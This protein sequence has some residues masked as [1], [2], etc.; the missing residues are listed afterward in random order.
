MRF[1]ERELERRLVDSIRLRDRDDAAL[2]PEQAQDREVLVRLRAR[3]LVGVDHEQEQVDAC[4]ARDHRAH[5][6]LVP[7]HVD[8]GEAPAVRQIERGVA[9]VDRDAPC[10]LL[11]EP[12]GVLSGQR[13][14]EPR[15]AVVDVAGGAERQGHLACTSPSS[16]CSISKPAPSSSVRHSGSVRSRPPMTSMSRSSHLPPFG[17]LPG[18]M[19]VSVASSRAPG[20]SRRADRAAGS[21]S[22]V[23]RPSCG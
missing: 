8:D 3:A 4:R 10:V 23:R 15:L 11:R 20:P 9:E 2:D 18:G 14:H 7:G 1:R 19:T 16:I 22:P 12:V 13:T 17:S 5:E 21:P 6:A